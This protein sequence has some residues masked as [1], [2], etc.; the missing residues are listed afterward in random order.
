MC[1]STHKERK[2]C[3]KIHHFSFPETLVMRHATTAAC[4][5]VSFST[6]IGRFEFEH[7]LKFNGR[8]RLRSNSNGPNGVKFIGLNMELY[9]YC[10]SGLFLLRRKRFVE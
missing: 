8:S 9:F 10:D 1:A 2:I 6:L 4:N 7:A 3:L 5:V